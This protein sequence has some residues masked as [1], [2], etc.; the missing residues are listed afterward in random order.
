MNLFFL[1]L[2]MS[3]NVFFIRLT[4]GRLGSKLGTQT[5]LLL[6]S[7]G[8]KSG[9]EY[10]TPVAYFFTN[11]IYFLVA[12]NW[13]KE[14]NAAWFYNLKAHPRTVIEVKGRSIPVEASEAE[15]AEYEGLW[16]YAIQ[17]HPPYLR[18]KEMTPRHIP[19]IVLRPLES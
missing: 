1:K 3:L 19:I 17:H 10:I 11:G 18:Y 4:R 2:F 14:S 12:S 6:H 5:I 7:I 9:K 13:G 16:A 8:R 15:G